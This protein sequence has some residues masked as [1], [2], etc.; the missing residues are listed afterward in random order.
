ME[1]SPLFRLRGPDY[2]SGL[3][4]S[5]AKLPLRRAKPSQNRA[6]TL[7]SWFERGARLKS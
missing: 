3:P 5:V 1:S 2:D 4:S 6:R 7:H